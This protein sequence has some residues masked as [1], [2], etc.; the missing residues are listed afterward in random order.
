[1]NVQVK[2]RDFLKVLGDGV[3]ETLVW[4]P[5]MERTLN[6]DVSPRMRGVVEKCNFCHGRWQA[7]RTKAAAEGRR[8]LRAGEYV[9]ACVEACPTSAVRFGNLP[10]G[11]SELG[12]LIR[13]GRSFRLL[14]RL[15]TQPKVYYL[16]DREWVRQIGG[17]ALTAEGEA[18]THG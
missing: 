3:L 2:G 12:R 4:P 1:M 8:E 11:S 9:P 15:G 18:D 14:E 16:P 17:K 10:D 7:A 5:G 6:P 13:S